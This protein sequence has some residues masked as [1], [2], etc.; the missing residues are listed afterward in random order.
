MYIKYGSYQHPPEEAG[1]AS[2]S[3]QPRISSRGFVL[4]HNVKAI[5]QGDLVITSSQN[6]YDITNK[7]N[8]LNAALDQPFQDFGLYHD[9]GTP[10][11]HFLENYHPMNLTGNRCIHRQFAAEDSNA[12]YAT[13]RAFQYVIAAEIQNPESALIEYAESVTHVGDGGPVAHWEDTPGGPAWW[14][15]FP[16][17]VQRVVQ[18]GYAVTLGAYLLPPGPILGFPYYMANQT[19]IKRTTP[20]RYPQGLEGYRI[21]WNYTYLT[22]ITIPLFPNIR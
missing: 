17:T 20:I 6:Q 9:N 3:V 14:P 21:D 5:V 11:S 4:A 1:L 2:W 7:I 15:E 19:V 8:A 18:S 22:N 10:S 16:S 13:G 12:E